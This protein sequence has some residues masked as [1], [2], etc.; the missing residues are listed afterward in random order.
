MPAPEA[1]SLTV[2]AKVEA[3]T[4]CTEFVTAHAVHAGFAPARLGEIELVVEEVVTNICQHGYNDQAGQ[5]ELHCRRV[6][7]Q[8]LLLEFV[9]CGRP[10]DVLAQA[11]PGLTLDLDQREPGGLGVPLIRAMAE[12]VSYTREGNRNILHLIVRAER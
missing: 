6:D 4:Q 10:F 7:G 3:L 2:P 5:V 1:A 8:R 9:D 12:E 11:A